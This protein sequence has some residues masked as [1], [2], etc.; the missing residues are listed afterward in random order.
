VAEPVLAHRLVLDLD[1]ALRG[2]SVRSVVEAV[3]ADVPAPPVVA[4]VGPSG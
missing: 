4:P 2:A 1:R 3:L